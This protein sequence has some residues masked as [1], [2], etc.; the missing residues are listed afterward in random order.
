MSVRSSV[1]TREAVLAALSFDVAFTVIEV[2]QR[3]AGTESW[4]QRSNVRNQLYALGR[5]G[6]AICDDNR[7]QRW[8]RPS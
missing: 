4:T 2:A 5:D 8:M 7:P 6:L 3:I 1:A